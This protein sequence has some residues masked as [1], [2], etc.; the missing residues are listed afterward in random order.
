LLFETFK[1]FQVKPPS[2]RPHTEDKAIFA[3]DNPKFGSL[4]PFGSICFIYTATSGMTSYGTGTCCYTGTCYCGSTSA[5]TS[6]ASILYGYCYGDGNAGG[7]SLAFGNS[8][9]FY[10]IIFSMMASLMA[11]YGLIFSS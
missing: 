2:A 5:F 6:T 3:N 11:G 4:G 8:S 7:S 10:S 9:T 1:N